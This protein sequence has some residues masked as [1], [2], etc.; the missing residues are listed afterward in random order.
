[1]LVEPYI[2][3]TIQYSLRLTTMSLAFF[4]Y[5]TLSAIA[6]MILAIAVYN[7]HRRG[8]NKGVARNYKN[9]EKMTRSSWHNTEVT[10]LN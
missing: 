1:M 10:H 8:R 3:S 5:L 4:I 7:T 6:T 2:Y 9:T